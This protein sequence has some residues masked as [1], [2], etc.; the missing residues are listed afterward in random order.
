MPGVIAV[1]EVMTS[2]ATDLSAIVSNLSAAHAVAALPT[3]AVLSAA[4]DEVSTGLAHVF[5][6]YAR[7]YQAL[8]RQAT[9]FHDQFVQH[10]PASA[11]WINNL[12]GVLTHAIFFLIALAVIAFL[13]TAILSIAVVQA[14]HPAYYG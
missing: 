14:V 4:K 11:N 9:A 3:S 2:A 5:S 13:V 12:G 7:D 8:A 1:A 6:Q 10:L